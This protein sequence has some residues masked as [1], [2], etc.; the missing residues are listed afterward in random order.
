MLLAFW[1]ASTT[2][3]E[4]PETWK[5]SIPA[6]NTAGGMFSMPVILRTLKVCFLVPSPLMAALIVIVCPLKLMDRRLAW[7]RC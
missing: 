5:T 2:A 3:G 1:T 7:M 4:A 6:L